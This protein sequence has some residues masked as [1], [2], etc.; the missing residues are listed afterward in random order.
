MKLQ[1]ETAAFAWFAPSG[2]LLGLMCL[3]V[4]DT[5]MAFDEIHHKGQ[6]QIMI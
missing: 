3:H 1:F 2:N 6:D 4:D 5:V